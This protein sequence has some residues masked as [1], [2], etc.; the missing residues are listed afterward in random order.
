MNARTMLCALLLAAAWP[1]AAGAAEAKKDVIVLLDGSERKVD[2]V[3]EETYASVKYTV[4]G[5]SDSVKAADVREVQYHDAPLAFK[6]ATGLI[7][8]KKYKEALDQLKAAGAASGVRPWIKAYL[9]FLTAECYRGLGS[10]DPAYFVNAIEAYDQLL[11]EVPF[12]RF[13]PAA[14][15][16]KGVCQ[17]RAA[18]YDDAT[19]TFTQL[20]TEVST[21]SLPTAW[22]LRG[23]IEAA[24]VKEEQGLWDEA[25]QKY[26][27]IRMEAKNAGE[28]NI[29]NMATLRKGICKIKQK[30]FGEAKTYFERIRTEEEGERMRGKGETAAS[31]EVRAGAAIGLGYCFWNDKNWEEARTQFLNALV[32]CPSSDEFNA[33]A[34]YN[35]GLCYEKLKDK[36]GSGAL[37][38]A[39]VLMSDLLERYP[40]SKWAKTARDAGYKVLETR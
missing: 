34:L 2:S 31:R 20:V 16:Q 39:K 22:G 33:E 1:L 17:R 26:E 21:K 23:N 37:N 27:S 38:R 14:L 29:E 19:K 12:T 13:L 30:K 10:S 15:F 9:S 28:K 4:S 25:E 11:K 3:D 36:E 32:V 6:N 24:Q 8:S 18:K 35:A 40:G 7:A 5:R